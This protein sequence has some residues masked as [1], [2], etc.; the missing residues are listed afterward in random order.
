MRQRLWQFRG[1][2]ARPT[3]DVAAFVAKARG[4]R[5]LAAMKTLA[6]SSIALLAAVACSTTDEPAPESTAQLAVDTAEAAATVDP[7]YLSVA[8]DMAQVVGGRFWSSSGQQEVIGEEDVALEGFEFVLT[9]ATA[10]R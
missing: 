2:G 6:C 3:D 4:L 1:F 5:Y 8:V 10:C 9:A 7:R